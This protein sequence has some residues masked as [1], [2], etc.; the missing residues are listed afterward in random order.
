MKAALDVHYNGDRATAACVVFAHWRDQTPAACLRADLSQVLPYRAGRFFEREL[1]GLLAVLALCPQTFE[2]I[3][4]DGYVHL[5]DG[6]DQGLGA[7]LAAA[8]ACKPAVVGVTKPPLKVAD[9][10]VTVYRGGSRKP[11]FISASG[12]A[13]HH[14]AQHIT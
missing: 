4:I 14:A 13:L 2:I 11:L 12:L 6:A 7:R 10:F 5:K 9:R 1:P 3:V 8:L